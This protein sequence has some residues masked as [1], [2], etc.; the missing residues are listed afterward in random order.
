MQQ[1]LSKDNMG[2]TDVEERLAAIQ[3]LVDEINE[4]TNRNLKKIN[5]QINEIVYKLKIES[6]KIK[7]KG[8]EPGLLLEFPDHLRLTVRVLLDL[9]MATAEEVSKK[10]GRSRSMESSYL[11][12][13]TTMGYVQKDRKGQLVYYKIK[14]DTEK[15]KGE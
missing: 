4:T 15:I 2:M 5:E 10:T 11:N 13:L 8:F 3:L 1:I 6:T 9:G 12:Q 7:S 14:F